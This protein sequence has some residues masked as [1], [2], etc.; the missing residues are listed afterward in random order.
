VVTTLYPKLAILG[1]TALLP[2]IDYTRTCLYFFKPTVSL[3]RAPYVVK[4]GTSR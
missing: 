1:L 3:L 4:I 2:L